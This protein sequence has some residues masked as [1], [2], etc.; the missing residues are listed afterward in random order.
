M[1]ISNV[2][3]LK[4]TLVKMLF[5]ETSPFR[6]EQLEELV[7]PAKLLAVSAEL[8]DYG[9]TFSDSHRD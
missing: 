6:N 7:I 3:D 8:V 5:P 4:F 2:L 1:Q 9:D